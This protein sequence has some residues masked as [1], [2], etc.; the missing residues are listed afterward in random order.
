MAQGKKKVVRAAALPEAE[1]AKVQAEQV[2]NWRPT[3]EAKK[4][5]TNLR[6]IAW[7]SWLVAIG[8]DRKSVV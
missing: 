6:I 1:A 5:A 2:A 4:Q 7:V 3:P 8:A